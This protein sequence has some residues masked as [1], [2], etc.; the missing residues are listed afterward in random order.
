[1]DMIKGLY[2]FAHPYTSK[3][4]R[5]EEANF[6][7]CC[8]RSAKLIKRGYYVYSPICHT[9]PIHMAWPEFLNNDERDL[10]M[11]LDV[12]IIY[13]T[14]FDG[15]ILAPEWEKSAGCTSE[16]ATFDSAQKPILLYEDIIR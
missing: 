15:I 10:W 1:M 11:D 13:R 5:A 12:L 3:D 9:H 2:Y 16:R 8:I 7:L 14:K 6:R 4:K